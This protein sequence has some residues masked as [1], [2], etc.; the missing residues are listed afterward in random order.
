M[1]SAEAEAM[2]K[3]VLYWTGLLEKGTVIAF[4][5]V[6]DPKGPWGV[7]LVGVSDEAELRALEVGDPAIQAEIGMRYESYPMPRLV[8]ARDGAKVG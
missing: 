3:H 5:P 1:T 4:G 7:G 8:F 2:K 6:A